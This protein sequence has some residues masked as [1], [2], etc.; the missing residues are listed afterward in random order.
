MG[1]GGGVGEG[2]KSLILNV[3]DGLDVLRQEEIEVGHP[4]D[5]KS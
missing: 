4:W 5:L 3:V 2:Y 1:G